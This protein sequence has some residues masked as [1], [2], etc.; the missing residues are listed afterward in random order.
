[1]ILL[2]ACFLLQLYLLPGRIYMAAW[3]AFW[4]LTHNLVALAGFAFWGLALE[5]RR[6]WLTVFRIGAVAAPLF[7]TQC[8]SVLVNLDQAQENLT[9]IV[10]FFVGFYGPA[11]GLFVGIAAAS[12]SRSAGQAIAILVYIIFVACLASWTFAVSNNF[13]GFLSEGAS[14]TVYH[15]RLGLPRLSATGLGMLSGVGAVLS[16]G[17]F[18][19]AAGRRYGIISL[20]LLCTMLFTLSRW[21]MLVGGFGVVTLLV[22]FRGYVAHALRRHPAL[23]VIF[24]SAALGFGGKFVVDGWLDNLTGTSM[25]QIDRAVSGEL[26]GEAMRHALDLIKE[27]PL[28]GH[29][30]GLVYVRALYYYRGADSEEDSREPNH[31]DLSPFALPLEVPHSIPLEIMVEGGILAGIGLLI[32]LTFLVIQTTR[33]VGGNPRQPIA[34][35]CAVGVWMYILTMLMSNFNNI[36]ESWITFLYLVGVALGLTM[37]SASQTV[38]GAAAASISATVCAS[39]DGR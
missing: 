4:P 26:R 16:L 35:A 1:L 31:L 37:R 23:A 6:I 11:F 30:A 5:P 15:Y 14:R 32:L 9:E 20:F 38:G 17:L 10:V 18:I 34:C 8:L 19:A 27:R 25:S 13:F 22:L 7:I 36:M 12:T 2:F 3:G 39:E 33:L 24:V 21:S 29:G 28:L